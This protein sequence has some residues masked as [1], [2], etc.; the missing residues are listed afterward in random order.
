MKKRQRDAYFSEVREMVSIPEYVNDRAD[1][2]SWVSAMFFV[3]E[4]KL[5][6]NLCYYIRPRKDF[7]GEYIFYIYDS[8]YIHDIEKPELKFILDLAA[9][10]GKGVFIPCYPLAPKYRY[11]DVA[12]FL[13]QAYRDYCKSF[14]SGEL[15]V[16]ASGVGAGIAF[17]F[18]QKIWEYGLRVADK[19]ILISPILDDEY[20]PSEDTEDYADYCKDITVCAGERSRY[21]SEL[22]DLNSRLTDEGLDMKLF[23]YRDMEHDFYLHR[24]RKTTLHMKRILTDLITGGKESAISDHMYEIKRRGD[25]TKRYPEVFTDDK[26]VRFISKSKLFSKMKKRVNQYEDFLLAASYKQF[27]DTVKSFLKKYPNGTVVYLGCSLDTMYDRVDNGRVS[28][29]NLDR[30]GKM[31]LRKMYTRVGE[32]EFNIEK[33]VDDI[34]WMDDIKSDTGF[35]LLI[36]CRNIF[37][38]Y[39]NKELKSYINKVYERFPGAQVVFDVGRQITL[40]HSDFYELEKDVHIRS[41]KFFTSY[42][43]RAITSWNPAFNCEWSKSILEGIEPPQ[44]AGW[45]LRYRIWRDNFGK[46]YKLVKMTLGIEKYKQYQNIYK[47]R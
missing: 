24:R 9:M 12:E 37:V 28:W 42:P 32:R 11:D 39:S 19:L 27:D 15:V 14:G 25:I 7:N 33:S 40:F 36:V 43:D 30:S 21:R 41:R 2:P 26:A 34:S 23:E 3:D 8:G 6:G 44:N 4:I 35:G 5:D 29:Y 38:Y 18:M 1:I 47:E 17:Y 46:R 31:A 22:W 16:V 20:L 10:S 45:F 13:R